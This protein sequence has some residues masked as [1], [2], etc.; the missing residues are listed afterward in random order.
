MMAC[1]YRGFLCLLRRL[2]IE[3]LTAFRMVLALLIPL[4]MVRQPMTDWLWEV[5]D[6][7]ERGA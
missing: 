1:L 4:V 5:P 2:L 3:S 6:S 7:S